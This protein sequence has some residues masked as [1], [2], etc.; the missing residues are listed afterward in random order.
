MMKPLSAFELLTAW[1]EGLDQPLL[2]KTMRLL[3]KA[4]SV[5]DH[6]DIGLLSIGERDARLLQLREWLFGYRLMNMTHCPKCKETVEWETTTEKLHLQ[7]LPATLAVRS[8]MLEKND[9]SINFRLPNTHD[10]THAMANPVYRADQKKLL[11][12]CI[13]GINK[14]GK[15]YKEKKLPDEVLDALSRRMEEEDPQA[16]IRMNIQCPAC[17]HEWEARFDIVSFLWAEINNWA[18]RMMQE[19]YLLARSFGWSEKDILSMSTRRRQLYL[20]MIQA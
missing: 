13:V 12:D 4:C 3:G 18:Q 20:Q 1:E 14:K 16:D 7:K 9:Y 6:N 11:S 17:S 8:F 15:K 5:T 10:I 19:V 2:E